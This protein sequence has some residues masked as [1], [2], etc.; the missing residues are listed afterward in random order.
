M[1]K[2]LG[3][4]NSS[5]VQKVLWCCE[6][7]GLSWQ[8]SDLGGPYGGNRDPDYLA[9][10][11]NGLIPTLIDG[12]SVLWESNTIIRYLASQYGDGA[13]WISDAAVRAR[14]ERWMDWQLT[15]IN[16]P[17]VPLYVNLIRTPQEGRD[18]G[19]IETAHRA[20]TNAFAIL[21]QALARS[22]FLGG[23]RFSVN[24]IPLGVATYR[25][26]NLDIARE[27]CPNLKRWYDALSQRS[28]FQKQVMT[29]L[30]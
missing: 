19:Q 11:P 4:S 5:N 18:I 1:L 17:M 23:S 14:A 6:E 20:L 8:R 16:P 26:L 24:D 2:I 30:S 22:A 13:L 21:D 9:L 27:D 12:D 25:W 29:G 7:L 10:N 15:T 3:R 28:A